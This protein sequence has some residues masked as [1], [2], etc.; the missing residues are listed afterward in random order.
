MR[1]YSIVGNRDGKVCWY[2]LAF[3]SDPSQDD[4]RKR[5]S[6]HSHNHNHF[7]TAI[8]ATD[9]KIRTFALVMR[10]AKIDLAQLCSSGL[11]ASL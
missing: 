2:R 10:F 7:R 4:M 6:K 8:K 5:N 9:A 3:V 11:G 1:S